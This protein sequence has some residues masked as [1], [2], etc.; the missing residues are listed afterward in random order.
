MKKKII[1][2][3]F[4]MLF[5]FRPA[6]SFCQRQPELRFHKIPDELLQSAEIER[7]FVTKDGLLWFGTTKGLASF[8]GSEMVYYGNKGLNSVR[9]FRLQDLAEDED[10]NFWILSPEHQLIYFN[11][12]TGL[13]KKI[14]LSINEKIPSSQIEAVKICIDKNGLIWVGSWYRG[15]FVYNPKT[16]AHTH[17]NLDAHK[18]ED[19]QSRY[20]NSV[21]NIIEDKNDS[22]I[23]WLA[24]YGSGIYSFNK[25]TNLLLKKFKC[26][27]LKDSLQL[28]NTITDLKQVNDSIIWFSTWGHG[29]GE[30]NTKTGAYHPYERNSGYRVYVYGNGHVLEHIALKSD[31]EF[32]V[33]PRDTIPAIFNIHT[34]KYSFFNDD[35]LNKEY[36]RTQ[37]VKTWSENVY[38]EKG[39]ALFIASPRFN[40]FTNIHVGNKKKFLYPEITCMLWDSKSESY[41]A[42]I[43]LG[44]GVYVYDKNFQ[45]LRKITM[46]RYTGNGI[47]NTTSI[48]KL[49][50]DKGGH[51]WALG[52]R[53]CVYD[54]SSGR[55][56]PINKKWAFLKLLDTAMLDVATDARGLSYFNSINNNFIQFNPFTLEERKIPL[57]ENHDPSGLSFQNKILSDT[58][59]NYIY[60]ANGNGLYQY[61]TL[62]KLFRKLYIDSS[63]Y[64]NRS[65][66]FFSSCI[67]DNKGFVWL[68]TPDQ[69]L[70]KISPKNFKIADT[71]KFLNT[72]VDLSGAQLYGCYNKYLLISTFKSQLLF[73]TENYECIYVNRKNGL[74]LNQG[75]R[76]MECNGEVFFDYAGSGITQ[77]ASVADLTGPVKKITP[78]ITSILINNQPAVSDTL[79]SYL[80]Y[81]QLDYVHN[82][83][84]I[85]FSAIDLEFPDRLEYAYMLDKIDSRW[86]YTNN[87]DR[88]INYANLSPGKYIF[89]VKVR[90]WGLNWSPETTLHIIITPPF[91]ETW[92]FIALCFLLF[93][94]LLFWFVKQR[95]KTIRKQ[96]KLLAK[97]EK[98]LLE[99]E[100]KA[101]RAQMNPH[102]IFNCMNSIKSLIQKNDHEKAIAYLTIFSKLI[103]TI[104][105]NSDKREITLA[106]EIETCRFYT[107]LESMRF[108]NKFDYRFN[109]DDSLDLKSVMVP[110]L[111]IQPFIENAIWHGVMPKEEGGTVTVTIDKN[112]NTIQCSIDDD[113]IGR[114][115]SN[116]NK[117]KGESP[118]HQ[119]K[120]VRLTQSRLDLDNLLNERHAAVQIIDK[121]NEAGKATGTKVIIEL[122]EY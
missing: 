113:G 65:R 84:S 38:Y 109:V 73:N 44:E 59:R 29:M 97:H 30:Y 94:F 52:H 48:W 70:W 90:E 1:Y 20:E 39:G 61:N 106:D 16:N 88:K 32:Y 8:D 112:D 43:L 57:P 119:S 122:T 98:Q 63:F 6:I 110:A 77:F 22:N 105:Q 54:S 62:N 72:Q 118:A 47:P 108:G 40:L 17:Y 19:W 101:L 25:S 3:I 81:L 33:A 75:S 103:R 68:S 45:L 18:P 24:C 92:W 100:A 96:E 86:I 76:N 10:G 79:S 28:S 58:L 80:K 78:Y 120:G 85:G 114:E 46:P 56:I 82:T 104:F 9:N 60:F 27:D 35:E 4:S 50:R 23:L 99:L 93:S 87:S 31:S 67:L 34:K 36:P 11:R 53:T 55:F 102:F 7:F 66:Q 64:I 107:K 95:I 116:Q 26:F 2:F 121:K 91:W 115:V 117:F 51:L 74:L 13:F 21:R 69:Y 42:G 5:L 37:N 83:I 71:I 15:F 14:D 41:F 89:R 49:Y 12:K 111:I